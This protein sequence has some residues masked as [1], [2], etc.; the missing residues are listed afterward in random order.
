M[1]QTMNAAARGACAAVALG[2]LLIATAASQSPVR[3][4]EVILKELDAI[5]I[6]ALDHR[7]GGDDA[8]ANEWLGQLLAARE[9][10]AALILELFSAAPGHARIPEL[11]SE[12]WRYLAPSNAKSDAFSREIEGAV[13]RI[14]SATPKLEGTYV[15]AWTKVMAGH[16]SGT[17]D[18]GA[19]RDFI[20]LA[21]EDERGVELLYLASTLLRDKPAR[22]ALENRITTEFPSSPYAATIAAARRQRE[23]LGKPFDLSFTDA[24]TGSSVSIKGVRGKVVVVDFWATRSLPC[25]A[26]VR[27]LNELYARYH[28]RASNSSASVSTSPPPREDSPPSRSS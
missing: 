1:E 13:S 17:T 21:P 22:T 23:A 25:A 9:R 6:P 15:A 8:Y 7:R 28:D 3:T 12:R 14:S 20:K 11:L 10:R 2:G 26:L 4:P 18:I 19:A 5:A 27:Y 24:I 16:D